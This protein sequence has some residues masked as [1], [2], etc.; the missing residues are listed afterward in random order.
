M[1]LNFAENLSR[2]LELRGWKQKDLAREMLVTEGT[3]SHWCSGRCRPR[4]LLTLKHL[5]R[6]LEVKPDEL[7]LDEG[8]TQ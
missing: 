5:A 3:V 2:L 7:L 6:V 4:G 8:D 1:S